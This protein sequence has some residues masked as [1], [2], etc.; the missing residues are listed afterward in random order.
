AADEE[1][2]AVGREDEA[3][4][5]GRAGEDVRFRREAEGVCHVV[6]AVDDAVNSTA[7]DVL[8]GRVEKGV[9]E[10]VRG[11]GGDQEQRGEDREAGEGAGGGRGRGGSPVR[12]GGVRKDGFGGS[13]GGP[14]SP[15]GGGWWIGQQSVTGQGNAFFAPLART[16][17]APE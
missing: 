4:G 2:L 16:S 6:V 12:A 9:G 11:G 15:T 5:P 17:A 1:R 8:E 7:P 14:Y 10:G 13:L 3:V